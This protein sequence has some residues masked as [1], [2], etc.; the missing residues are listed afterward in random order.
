MQNLKIYF[1]SQ[2]V[3][4]IKALRQVIK[5]N[6]HAP[7]TAI[8]Y[9][10]GLRAEIN[11]LSYCALTIGVSRS[12]FL[13]NKYGSHIRRINYKK[14]AILYIVHGEYVVI[15]AIIPSAIITDSKIK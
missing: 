3:E 12:S 13:I 11:K 8:K 4:D 2:S 15:K 9:V 1:T 14:M 6:Y 10:A 7:L 5:E